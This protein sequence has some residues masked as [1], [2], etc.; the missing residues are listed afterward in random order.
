MLNQLEGKV[1]FI[2]TVDC[3]YG[4]NLAK[5]LSA[6]GATVLGGCL[7]PTADGLKSLRDYGVYLIKFETQNDE[8]V[9]EGALRIRLR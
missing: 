9:H 1:I 7:D 5:L 8:S 4:Q 2:S 6:N 3:G